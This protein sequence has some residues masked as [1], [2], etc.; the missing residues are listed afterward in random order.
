MTTLDYE[1]TDHSTIRMF[2][3]LSRS[4]WGLQFV[5]AGGG[6]DSILLE[7]DLV[8]SINGKPV[9]KPHDAWP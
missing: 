1:S 4:V 8:L 9:T 3:H 2:Y 6:C 5:F 7:G